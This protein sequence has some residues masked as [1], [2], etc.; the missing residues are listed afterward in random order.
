MEIY[1]RAFYGDSFENY[2]S[3]TI[4]KNLMKLLAAKKNNGQKYDSKTGETTTATFST[5]G[6]LLGTW[7]AITSAVSNKDDVDIIVSA[8]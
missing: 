5:E 2:Y 8:Q 1:L 7:A 6:S 3:E 4:E